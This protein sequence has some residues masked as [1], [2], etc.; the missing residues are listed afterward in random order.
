MDSC[1]L[2]GPNPNTFFAAGGVQFPTSV[3]FGKTFLLVGG[4]IRDPGDEDD[5]D[6]DDDDDDDEEESDVRWT[7]S[8]QILEF[9]LGTDS[10]VVREERL[11]V[12]VAH[13][14]AVLVDGGLYG[15]SREDF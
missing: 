1:D 10:F 14:G 4:R 6:D 9:D 2:T 5:K 7:N 12:G 15:C 8:D 11:P 3:A 13:A